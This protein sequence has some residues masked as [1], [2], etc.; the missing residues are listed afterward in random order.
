[1]FPSLLKC[2]DLWERGGNRFVLQAELCTM[3][4]PDLCVQHPCC[5][6]DNQLPSLQVQ[7]GLYGAESWD[8]QDPAQGHSLAGPVVLRHQSDCMC[9]AILF[10]LCARGENAP[11]DSPWKKMLLLLDMCCHYTES[12]PFCPQ[13][14]GDARFFSKPLCLTRLARFTLEAYCSVASICPQIIQSEFGG[15]WES[16]SNSLFWCKLTWT[17]LAVCKP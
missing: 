7:D 8:G 2:W 17:V 3:W 14:T 12:L 9:G 1:M 5:T 4:K 6:S 16:N 13:G 11:A 15:G 10:H